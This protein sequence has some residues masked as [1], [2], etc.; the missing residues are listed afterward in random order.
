[1]SEKAVFLDLQGTLGGEAFGNIT[2]FTLFDYSKEALRIL[3]KCGFLLF[4]VTNQSQIAKGIISRDDFDRCAKKLVSLLAD[5]GI[6]ITEIFVCPHQKTDRCVC[7][8]PNG[9]F[10]H[11][12]AEKYGVS[13]EDSYFIGDIYHSDIEMARNVG[14]RAI[15]VLTGKG[16]DSL[17]EMKERPYERV[18]VRENVL[19]AAKM[20]A[21]C[22][23][24][25]C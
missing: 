16:Q 11:L 22:Q 24:K 12:A 14:A 4:V 20:I 7:R 10:P 13:L 1:M 3:E 15:L 5:E 19:E 8:K 25:E 9:Y 23:W 17:L 18:V 21:A 2:D 6:H